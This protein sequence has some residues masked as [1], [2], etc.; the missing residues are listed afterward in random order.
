MHGEQIGRSRHLLP[1]FCSSASAHVHGIATSAS[2]VARIVDHQ[3][4]AAVGKTFVTLR[5]GHD[6]ALARLTVAHDLEPLGGELAGTGQILAH[7][8]AA[9]L[10]ET[11]V[12]GGAA[13][14][15]GEPLYRDRRRPE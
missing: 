6:L 4:N 2:P 7:G 11:A 9:P 1:V 13:A 5:A 3:R 10:A 12:V 15:V 8:L 14:R